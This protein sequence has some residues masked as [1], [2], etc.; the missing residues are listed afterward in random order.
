MLNPAPFESQIA[1]NVPA[2]NRALAISRREFELTQGRKARLAWLG[3]FNNCIVET[4]GSDYAVIYATRFVCEGVA[5]DGGF[6][7]F[8]GRTP[9]RYVVRFSRIGCQIV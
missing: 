4:M 2:F 6:D 3:M 8:P 9:G 7:V 1:S 5:R